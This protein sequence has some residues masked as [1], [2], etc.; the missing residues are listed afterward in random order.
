MI[1]FA[2]KLNYGA[3]AQLG[4]RYTGSVEVSGSSPLCSTMIN[5]FFKL[6]RKD[7]FVLGKRDF[8]FLAKAPST[9]SSWEA[10]AGQGWWVFDSPLHSAE[11]KSRQ[12]PLFPFRYPLFAR[13][14]S[15][16]VTSVPEHYLCLEHG[17][18]RKCQIQ[19]YFMVNLQLLTVL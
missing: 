18:D 13:D 5:P 19:N 9:N 7:L 2:A 8:H 17:E 10:I 15:R 11:P 12:G 1:N 4:E 14:Q 3:L 6:W 16:P